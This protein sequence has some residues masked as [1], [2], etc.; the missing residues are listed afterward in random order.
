MEIKKRILCLDIGEKRIGIAVSDAMWFGSIP[1]GTIKRDNNSIKTIIDYLKE[2]NTDTILIGLP[3]NMDGS[4]GFQAERCLDL[5]RLPFVADQLKKMANENKTKENKDAIIENLKYE[6]D[7]IIREKETILEAF[8]VCIKELEEIRKR[9][10]V[11]TSKKVQDF[12]EQV[13]EDQN[14]R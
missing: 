11:L 7:S 6:R 3:Y 12:I 9:F 1:I 10:M 4:L 2:Y 5:V 8:N 14:G 13:K